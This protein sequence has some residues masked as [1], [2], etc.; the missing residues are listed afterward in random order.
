M[1]TLTQ[2]FRPPQNQPTRRHVFN[3]QQYPCT[4]P[5]CNHWFRNKSGLTQ[6]LNA[7]HQ[8]FSPPP[9]PSPEPVPGVGQPGHEVSSGDQHHF[10]D[11]LHNG[12]HHSSPPPHVEAQFFG[13]GDKLY[14]NYHAKMNG[15][16]ICNESKS[17]I[18]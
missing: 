18:C 8:V 12:M 4:K 14:R 3:V 6:H 7:V 1:Q 9:P 13:P 5:H 17:K 16:F 15:T 2:Y 10:N 11:P